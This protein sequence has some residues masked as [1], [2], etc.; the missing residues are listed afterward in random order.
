[1]SK[2]ANKVTI[3]GLVVA[4][5]IIYG[6][7]GTS[8]LYVFN[9]ILNSKKVDEFLIVGG[10]SCIIW[11]LTLQT[12][13]KYVILTLKADNKGE[14]GIFSLYTLVRRQKKWLVIPAMIGGA[15]LLADGM[16]TPPISVTSAI[17]GLKQIDSFKDISQLK[18]V[19]IVLGILC[20]LFFLQRFGSASIG[21]LFG[22]IMTVWFCMLAFLGVM[23]L[24]DYPGIFKSFNPYYAVKLLTVYPKGFWILG[25]VFLC[26]TGAEALYSD[27]GHCGRA[28]IRY[29]WI[30][31][32]S[33]LLL[34]YLGQ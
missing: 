28:N 33:C 1:M 24:S 31:V 22:P 30:F 18:V 4:L 32:K 20:L 6:D 21:K 16:I 2:Q 11:T 13:I 25:A 9:A 29:S 19:Y 17:E 23:H 15:A 27:L 8:P 12:T 3:A 14:G 7:I 34:N 5:G 10:L 26:T